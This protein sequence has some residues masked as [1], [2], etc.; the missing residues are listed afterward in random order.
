MNEANETILLKTATAVVSN[1]EF[2]RKQKARVL[3]DD[4]SQRSYINRE[5]CDKLKLKAISKRRVVINGA[6]AR[7]T[8]SECDVV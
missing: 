5:L 7:S 2:T 8:M 4:A 6:C 1:T 3:S